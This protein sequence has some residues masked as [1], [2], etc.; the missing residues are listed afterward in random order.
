MIGCKF[1]FTAPVQLPPDLPDVLLF[2]GPI[3]NAALFWPAG[4]YGMEN[5]ELNE[6]VADIRAQ[7]IHSIYLPSCFQDKGY[8]PDREPKDI[9]A[10]SWLPGYTPE[11][12]AE[13]I[14]QYAGGP[15]ENR[16]DPLRTLERTLSQSH[17]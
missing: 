15:I 16:D 2:A 3:W 10:G 6:M 14:Q 11:G 7:L 9:Q 17:L 12:F 5:D 1:P 4:I 8:L 13:Y